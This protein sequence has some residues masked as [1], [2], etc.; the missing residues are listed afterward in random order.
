M[1]NELDK[2][3]KDFKGYKE[4]K[5][6]LFT[7]AYNICDVTKNKEISEKLAPDSEDGLNDYLDNH[8]YRTM[9]LH[10]KPCAYIKILC[11]YL[12]HGSFR[13]QWKDICIMYYSIH[14]SICYCRT[15]K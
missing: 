10:D 8:F 6:G 13:I 15:S 5:S 3:T 1:N 2:R 12:T 9:T 11:H 14:N 7:H 4:T